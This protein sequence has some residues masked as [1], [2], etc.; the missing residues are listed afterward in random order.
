MTLGKRVSVYRGLCYVAVQVVGATAGSALAKAMAVPSANNAVRAGI[1]A[2]APNVDF[3][4][5]FVG[6]P[7][8]TYILCLT[9]LAATN[10][11]LG[12]SSGFMR[13]LL[14]Y[15]NGIAVFL[16]HMV[17]IP[18]DGCSI[19]PARSFGAAAVAGIW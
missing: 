9:I 5:A 3:G 19:N 13:P 15:A 17:L 1:K 6:E 2:L 14:P 10:G 12:N 4:S 18:I 11:E 7:A 16:G 8:L